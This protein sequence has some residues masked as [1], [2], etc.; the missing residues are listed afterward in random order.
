VKTR[1]PIGP[2]LALVVVVVGSGCAL[3]AGL[4][5]RA[6]YPDAG[7]E[8]ATAPPDAPSFDTT[9]PGDSAGSLDSGTAD[10]G[11]AGLVYFDMTN[12]AN[13]ETFDLGG[14]GLP[15][16]G[17]S[18]A[19]FD[20]RGV[21]FPPLYGPLYASNPGMIARY[22]TTAPFGAASA[23]TTFG[24]SGIDAGNV[25]YAGGV[26]DGR[27]VHLSPQA[28]PTDGGVGLS[29]LIAR[30]DT[31][32]GFADAA[33]WSTFN[34]T[35]LATT[36]RGFF[37]SVFD[38]RYVYLVPY[39]NSLDGGPYD[40]LVVRYD[41]TAASFGAD[42]FSTFNVTSISPA[43]EGFLGAVF[44]GRYVYFVPRANSVSHFTF[45]GLVVRFDTEGSFASTAAWTSFDVSKVNPAAIGF[46]GGVFDG[47][48]LYLVPSNN[49]S[50]GG[51]DGV[52]A[53]LDTTAAFGAAGSWATFDVSTLDTRA[54]GFVGGVFDG[55]YLYLVPN[56]D[57]GAD[58][59]FAKDGTVAR[60]DT[61]LA[62]G[63]S[64]AWTFFDVATISSNAVGFSGGAFDGE[65]VYLVPNSYSTV[66]RFHAKSPGSVPP[67]VH[68][69][70][71]L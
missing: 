62:L 35:A 47:R 48:Y 6:P 12:A 55:R 71:F 23:W 15:V 65:Y 4:Q 21:Y 67:T 41:T 16:Q 11:D 34:T 7:P 29:G 49:G 51:F 30:Y 10:V 68:G 5:D 46:G 66:A 14:L 40:G 38:G 43:A 22:D 70:S 37:G 57:V 54:G 56:T 63:S 42:A 33:A 2:F 18:G 52:V 20:G 32:G 58:G 60:Y 25:G 36:A 53:R 9:L 3:V 31:E 45:D 61:T 64:Q 59:G 26:F 69:G 13:W 28:S 8:D 19:I 44:D 27:Y 50:L 1:R 39:V 17:F 24:L